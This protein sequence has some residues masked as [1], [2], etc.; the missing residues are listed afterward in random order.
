[1]ELLSD[2]GVVMLR[3]TFD[4]A[5]FLPPLSAKAILTTLK[6]IVKSTNFLMDFF[7]GMSL[8][9]TNVCKDWHYLQAFEHF[10]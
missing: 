8:P 2:P 4:L 10:F 6:S 1:M 9:D 3:E 7:I 5:F